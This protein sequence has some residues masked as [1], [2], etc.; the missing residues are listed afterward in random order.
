MTMSQNNKAH[1]LSNGDWQA[2]RP[3]E[4]LQQI[5]Y[6]TLALKINAF[7]GFWLKKTT[8]MDPFY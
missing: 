8:Q 3:L 2:P 6:I 1:L 4:Q 7:L 5:P